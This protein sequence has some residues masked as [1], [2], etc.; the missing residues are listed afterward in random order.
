MIVDSGGLAPTDSSLNALMLAFGLAAA[1]MPTVTTGVNGTFNASG[2]TSVIVKG[3]S[4]TTTVVLPTSPKRGTWVRVTNDNNGTNGTVV[5]QTGGSDLIENAVSSTN[6]SNVGYSGLYAWNGTWWSILYTDPTTVNW[7]I[8]IAPVGT[9]FPGSTGLP[10]STWTTPLARTT[11]R[12]NMEAAHSWLWTINSGAGNGFVPTLITP[13]VSYG[14]VWLQEMDLF[15]TD[16]TGANKLWLQYFQSTLNPI[17]MGASLVPGSG[18]DLLTNWTVLQSA[19]SDL[20][21]SLNSGLS[22]DSIAGGQYSAAW[23]TNLQ[24]RTRLIP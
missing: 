10:R 9:S 15:V 8:S 7:V 3:G 13:A 18:L 21:L 19:G 5:V 14:T 6:L 22:I 24:L 23:F 17:A 16:K 4:G 1:G 2:N 12:T 20:S 11:A